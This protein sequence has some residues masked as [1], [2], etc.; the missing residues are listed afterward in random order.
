MG[1]EWMLGENVKALSRYHI[2]I[3]GSPQP[4]LNLSTLSLAPSK[5]FFNRYNLILLNG[6]FFI[7]IIITLKLKETRKQRQVI[8]RLLH[9]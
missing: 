2:T 5:G 9:F 3:A 1:W 7:C 8:L 4:L 6:H